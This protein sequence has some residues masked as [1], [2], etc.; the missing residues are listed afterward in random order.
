MSN[1]K[2]KITR[3]YQA[4]VALS[5]A[6]VN[7]MLAYRAAAIEL[8]KRRVQNRG[9]ANALRDYRAR[10]K[11]TGTTE[12]KI[13]EILPSGHALEAREEIEGGEAAIG[14]GRIA[15]LKRMLARR[16]RDLVYEDKKP[17]TPENY[18]G[19]EIELIAE[20]NERD[21]AAG[22][23]SAG[24]EGWVTRHDDGSIN[25]NGI[26][27][28]CDGCWNPGE[29]CDCDEDCHHIEQCGGHCGSKHYTHELCVLARQTEVR[30][31]V[32]KLCNFLAGVGAK[33]NASCGL[34]VHLDMR[35]RQVEQAFSNLVA[36]QKF[37]FAM[38]PASR[39]DNEFCQRVTGRNYR[40]LHSRYYAVNTQSMREHNT[41]EVR[42][43]AGT[44]NATKICNWV[45]I[46]VA[47]VEAPEMAV[48]PRT[49]VGFFRQVPLNEELRAYMAAR[50]EKFKPQIEAEAGAIY[51]GY[52]PPLGAPALGRAQTSPPDHNDLCHWY[53]NARGEWSRWSRRIAQWMPVRVADL[54]NP[55]EPAQ[56]E[57]DSELSEVA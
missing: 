9:L 22:L 18:V 31:I 51:S 12:I 1:N 7:E 26:A 33:V 10:L 38:Q 4:P 14:P 24:L 3:R 50:I 37:L 28:G 39:Q 43:H 13:T 40:Q 56:L 42:L 17:G 46:L 2:Y 32:T 23:V 49:L 8:S 41:L 16:K 15:N 11:Q 30:G 21:M 27:R 19:I 54:A 20:V 53:R 25:M 48:T 34:H 47:I 52:T 5:P 29:D 45:D 57:G 6:E 44:V 36:A 55:D 35:Q